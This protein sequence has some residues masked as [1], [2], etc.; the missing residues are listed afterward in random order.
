MKV[1]GQNPLPTEIFYVKSLLVLSH[2]NEAAK[3]VSGQSQ[4]SV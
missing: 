2:K 3:E 4:A 1:V